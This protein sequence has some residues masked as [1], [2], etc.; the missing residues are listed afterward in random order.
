MTQILLANVVAETTDEEIG[1]LLGKYGF[2]A[3]SAIRRVPGDGSRPA[4]LISFEEVDAA[5]LSF[6]KPRI[7]DIYWKQRRISVRVL[8][9][10]FR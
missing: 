6:L 10:H 8:L 5:Q 9:D 1:Q 4:A 3:H 7:H 2:P